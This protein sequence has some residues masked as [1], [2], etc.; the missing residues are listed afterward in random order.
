MKGGSWSNQFSC[1]PLKSWKGLETIVKEI[2]L[3][4][5]AFPRPLP[6]QHI[7]AIL[8][9]SITNST[10]ALLYGVEGGSLKLN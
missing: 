3:S 4:I 8:L 5:A 9:P 6:S 7:N 10:A 1:Q 2:S